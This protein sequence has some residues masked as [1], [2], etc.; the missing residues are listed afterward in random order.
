[1]KVINAPDVKDWTETKNC[2]QCKAKL[3]IEYDDLLFRVDQ[4]YE[5]Y[6]SDWDSGGSY[7]SYDTYF[8][9]CP[10]CD[11]EIYMNTNTLPY[12]VKQHAK[13]KKKEKK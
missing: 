7:V 3:E 13:S 8:V 1:M 5:S 12:L 2:G 9:K 6:G 10:I 11:Y 4:K